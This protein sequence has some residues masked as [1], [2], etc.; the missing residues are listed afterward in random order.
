MTCVFVETFRVE[1]VKNTSSWGKDGPS[2]GPFRAHQI[3][4]SRL[5][6]NGFSKKLSTSELLVLGVFLCQL[7]RLNMHLYT[8]YK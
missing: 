2:F 8:N 6:S 5:G 3:F 1:P 7:N 4:D